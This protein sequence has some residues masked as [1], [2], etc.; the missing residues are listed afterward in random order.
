MPA[1]VLPD[2]NVDVAI[3]VSRK[4]RA[5]MV[6]AAAVRDGKITIVRK[7]KKI[8][9]KCRTGAV[10]EGWIEVTDDSV[11]PDDEILLPE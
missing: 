3:E 7:G 4:D 9:L 5:L 2:M 8:T 1:G 10:N 11:A 6:P